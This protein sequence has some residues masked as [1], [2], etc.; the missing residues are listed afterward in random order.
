[1]DKLNVSTDKYIEYRNLSENFKNIG[2]SQTPLECVDTILKCIDMFYMDSLIPNEKRLIPELHPYVM[3][4]SR[5]QDQALELK[6]MLADQQIQGVNRL[7]MAENSFEKICQFRG[8]KNNKKDFVDNIVVCC[9]YFLMN[10]IDE[11]QSEK[12]PESLKL[13]DLILRLTYTNSEFNKLLEKP[14]AEFV[15]AVC[16][17]RRDVGYK[18]VE[19]CIKFLVD[20]RNICT[21]EV[22]KNLENHNKMLNK[23]D[24]RHLPINN[25]L[26]D[27]NEITEFLEEE[28]ITIEDICVKRNGLIWGIII[29]GV[30]YIKD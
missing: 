15:D 21:K 4:I 19:I 6:K 11:L 7:M 20:L 22:E 9:K 23:P 17:Y 12:K 28:D 18:E 14:G 13:K 8:W 30:V 25:M 29:N 2:K 27:I 16:D 10:T 24:G 5:I 26:T 3:P 1:M